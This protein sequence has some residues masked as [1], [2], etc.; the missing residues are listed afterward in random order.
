MCFQPYT[1]G[2]CSIMAGPRQ[3]TPQGRCTHTDIGPDESTLQYCNLDG[4]N[5]QVFENS[6][7]CQ[8]GTAGAM[9]S[10]PFDQCINLGGNYGRLSCG[11]T[12]QA[13]PSQT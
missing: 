11:G 13:V 2:N 9:V 6:S 8:T 5:I 1:D 3:C 7:S 10:A 4:V 12:R